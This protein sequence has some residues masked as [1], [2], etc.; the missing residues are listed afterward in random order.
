MSHSNGPWIEWP[1]FTTGNGNGDGRPK[2]SGPR[3][4]IDVTG[5]RLPRL[6]QSVAASRCFKCAATLPPGTDFTGTCPKC[7]AQLHCCKQCVNFESSTR[8]Q[9]MKPIPVRI[10]IK[11]QANECTL[12]SPRV[13]VAREVS[14]QNGSASTD[15]RRRE[16]SGPAQRDGRPGRIQPPLQQVERLRGRKLMVRTLGRRPASRPRNSAV[17]S[18]W[19]L[20]QRVRIFARSALPAA[21]RNRNNMIRIPQRLSTPLG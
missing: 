3:P 21:F 14:G 10:A 20:R 8:F 9:C 4:P 5:P 7:N 11:D 15:D 18:R 2:P 6:V 16:R 12:F 19:H 13:T 17:A 1:F